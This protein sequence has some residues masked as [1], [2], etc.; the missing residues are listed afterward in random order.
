MAKTDKPTEEPIKQIK[1][2]K[3]DYIFA[4]GRRKQAVA[5]VRL[6][7]S[8]KDGLK[9]GENPMKKGDI[10]VNSLPIDTYFRDSTSKTIYSEP[11]QA[12][13]VLGKFVFTIK[14]AGG[15]KASQLDAIVHGISRALNALDPEKN[16]SILRK[17]GFLTRDARIRQRRKVGMGGKSRRKKQSPK[18]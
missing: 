6:Y 13:N 4:V 7:T 11:L 10:T 18:R 16:H 17:K 12:T 2:I 3:R 9:I 14:V 8:V 5:R 15:G 1:M